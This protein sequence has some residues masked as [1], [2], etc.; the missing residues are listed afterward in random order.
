VSE[1]DELDEELEDELE[2]DP[3][4]LEEDEASLF[5]ELEPEPPAEDFAAARLSVR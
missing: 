1:D 3:D 5:D 4:E 2:G